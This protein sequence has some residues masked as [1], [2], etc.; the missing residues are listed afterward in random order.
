MTSHY[1]SSVPGE[2]ESYSVSVAGVLPQ[3]AHHSRM[4]LVSSALS[5]LIENEFFVDD[6][7]EGDE[8]PGEL[9]KKLHLFY[10]SLLAGGEN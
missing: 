9:I 4:I 3:G 1:V 5:S 8:T 10:S 6:D 7:G 2:L